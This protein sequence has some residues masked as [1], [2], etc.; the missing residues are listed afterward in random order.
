MTNHELLSAP[1]TDAQRRL[2]SC[3]DDLALEFTPDRQFIRWS[4]S[5]RRHP[6][7][8]HTLRKIHDSSLIIWLDLFT[9]VL[10]SFPA[11]DPPALTC[12]S[13][14]AVSTAGVSSISLDGVVDADE[15]MPS[16]FSRKQ[17]PG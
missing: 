15:E 9:Y 5:N 14:T 1:Q 6:R 3:L 2:Q 7:N 11:A 12:L 13:S 10:I 4:A 8:W 17:C 16:D